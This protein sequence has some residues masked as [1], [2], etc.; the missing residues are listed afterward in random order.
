MA[1]PGLA[2][3]IGAH[4]LKARDV[5]LERAQRDADLVC[6]ALAAC[7]LVMAAQDVEK[8]RQALGA[9]HS[10]PLDGARRF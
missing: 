7:R 9:G 5:A 6:E 10:L 4:G 3:D 2:L 8:I 1:H